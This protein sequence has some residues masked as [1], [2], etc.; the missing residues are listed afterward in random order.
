[1]VCRGVRMERRE[2]LRLDGYLQAM[3]DIQSMSDSGVRYNFSFNKIDFIESPE[4]SFRIYCEGFIK[5]DRRPRTSSTWMNLGKNEEE[6]INK[7]IDKSYNILLKFNSINKFDTELDYA[8]RVWVTNKVVR[9]SENKDKT[10][11]NSYILNYIVDELGL[12]VKKHWKLNCDSDFIYDT[13]FYNVSDIYIL[14][15]EG[16]YFLLRFGLEYL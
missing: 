15:I 1:M 12:N 11:L 5:N 3:A 9:Y 6:R 10:Q 13:F 14:K 2:C 16:E 4:E 8:L 7:F